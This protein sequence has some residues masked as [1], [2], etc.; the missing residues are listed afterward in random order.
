MSTIAYTAIQV[1]GGVDTHQDTHVVAA[2]DDHMA[3]IP[4]HPGADGAGLRL[5]AR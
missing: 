1:T 4:T 2:V 5:P 3:A